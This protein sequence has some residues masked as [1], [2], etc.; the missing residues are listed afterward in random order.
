[1]KG[2]AIDI[3]SRIVAVANAIDSLTS[4]YQKRNLPTVAAL[5]ALQRPPLE[6]AFDP[7][8]LDAAL[9]AVPPF[10]IGAWV[11]LADGRQAIVT[12]V[13]E[14]KPCQPTV[15]ILSPGLHPNDQGCDQLDLSAPGAPS[16]T[17]DRDH[18]VEKFF[19]YTL[20]QPGAANPQEDP[21]QLNA[22][23]PCQ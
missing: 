13:K 11:E 15:G 17:K 10:P 21:K 16:I 6:G 19:Y 14:S 1:M 22:S 23:A 5:A 9:R 8:V 20:P 3:F 18:P 7:V 4:I 12:D 2:R